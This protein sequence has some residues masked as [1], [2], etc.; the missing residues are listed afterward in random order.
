[1]NIFFRNTLV[2][3]G[4]LVMAAC[5]VVSPLRTEPETREQ[6]NLV[7]YYAW[8]KTAAID[9][10]RNEM[11]FI[12][13]NAELFDPYIKEIQ[14]ALLYGASA[15]S[16]DFS[17]R[18]A[19]DIVARLKANEMPP[20]TYAEA[21]AFL[22]IIDTLLMQ[23][24]TIRLSE[25]E[26]MYLKVALSDDTSLNEAKEELEANKKVITDLKEQIGTLD[27]QINLLQEQ[28][29]ALTSI[30]QQLLDREQDQGQL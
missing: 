4:C 7:E 6:F 22:E 1:M 19:A 8:I 17:E 2:V 21:I 18:K 24:Q 20:I 25:L 5:N 9:E 27:D 15:I 13:S 12:E 3:I 10:L 16:T 29:E 11:E 14:L 23:R 26:N 28:I 30:E